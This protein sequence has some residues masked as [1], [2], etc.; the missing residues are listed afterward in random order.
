MLPL[1]LNGNIV[2]QKLKPYSQIVLKDRLN[3]CILQIKE[4]GQVLSKHLVNCKMK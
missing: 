1:F 3:S 4:N 2:S